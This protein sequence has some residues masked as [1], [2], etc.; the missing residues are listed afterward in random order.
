MAKIVLVLEQGVHKSKAQDLLSEDARLG[1]SRFYYW[2]NNA[3]PVRPSSAAAS[4][5]ACER[6]CVTM[7]SEIRPIYTSAL[8]FIEMSPH[9][10]RRLRVCCAPAETAIEAP[11]PGIFSGLR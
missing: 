3:C 4:A 9:L 1:F 5:S 10:H 2:S 11:H 8:H 6:E 7:F